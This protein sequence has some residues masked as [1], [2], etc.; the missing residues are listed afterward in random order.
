MTGSKES[1]KSAQ[2]AQEAQ[3]ALL[4]ILRFLVL[5]CREAEQLSPAVFYV[6]K[7]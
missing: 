3:K 7:G 6:R 1:Q 2:K 5:R 4:S